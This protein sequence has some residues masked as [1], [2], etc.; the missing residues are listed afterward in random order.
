MVDTLSN[1][2]AV[3][4]YQ[5]TPLR[6]NCRLSAKQPNREW[7]TPE[8][9]TIVT[10]SVDDDVLKW[11]EAQRNGISK[12]DQ[13]RVANLRRS[14]S[15]VASDAHLNQTNRFAITSRPICHSNSIGIRYLRK[16]V[17]NVRGRFEFVG[18]PGGRG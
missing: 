10:L 15:A 14:A 13:C 8:K 6:H 5:Q 3:L 9:K 7:R 4:I 12:S 18:Q 17:M 16:G 11:F 2:I 1:G